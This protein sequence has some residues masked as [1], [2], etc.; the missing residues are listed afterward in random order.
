MHGV[1]NQME[2]TGCLAFHHSKLAVGAV[3]GKGQEA[4]ALSVLDVP[5][6]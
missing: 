6:Q 5:T 2:L 4:A 3:A 1:P